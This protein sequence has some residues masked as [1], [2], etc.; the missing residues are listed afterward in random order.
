[1]LATF[2]NELVQKHI[3]SLIRQGEL[4]DDY[5]VETL[6]SDFGRTLFDEIV[7]FVDDVP[8]SM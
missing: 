2:D 7:E 4:P 6:K 3:K 1:M 8:T 5:T